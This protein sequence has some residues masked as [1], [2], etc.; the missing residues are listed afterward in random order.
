[1]ANMTAQG[2]L[3]VAGG[4]INAEPITDTLNHIMTTYNGNN[5]DENNVDYSSADGIM[6]L[7]QSQTR[8]AQL[9]M[10]SGALIFNDNINLTFGTGSDATI[11][12][13]GTNLVVDPAVVGSGVLSLQ[14]GLTVGVDDTGYDVQL[15]GATSG[16]YVI[17]DQSDDTLA[18]E[19][20][21]NLTFGTGRDADI[22]YDGTDLIIAPAV[23]GSGDLVVSGASIEFDDSEGVTFGTGK[24]ATVQYDGTNLVVNPDAVGSGVLSVQGGLT[25]GV[26]DTGFDVQLFGAT[27]GSS[28]LWDESADQL[29]LTASTYR[30]TAGN[31][32]LGDSANANMTLGLTINQGANDNEIF[33]LKSSDV[34]HGITNVTET[35][36]F[37]YLKKTSGTA[38]GVELA[39]FT[40]SDS[41]GG[42]GS[43][44]ILA[45]TGDTT[46]TATHTSSTRAMMDFQSWESDG[47]T[48]RSAPTGE[49]AIMSWA[50]GTTTRMLL[51]AE[52]E[53]HITNTTL[54][55]LD[56]EDDVG[57]LR[58][59]Q[60]QQDFGVSM[61]KWDEAIRASKADLVRLGIMSDE[62]TGQGLYSVQKMTALMGGA[63]WQTHTRMMN[64]L[65]KLE[66]HTGL[67]LLEAN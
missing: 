39:G 5:A 13:D 64:A 11:D 36:T 55:A 46:L 27:S 43:L 37:F 52:G 34:A 2:T 8:T 20:N 16:K 59:I 45:Y 57:L 61:S 42:E 48:S 24:D 10:S 17:W 49:E 22:Y 3:P 56:D 51:Q 35:D 54:V 50:A 4:D 29:L 18:L 14:G 30:Q 66:A 31:M 38:G 32:Y 23:V 19:D 12:Y 33:A 47:G 26:D 28:L 44:R 67:K 7:G 63:I 65:E 60:K 58:T 25:V 41:N 9:T 6:V 21:T 62:P 53:M 40:D 15:F 1:M